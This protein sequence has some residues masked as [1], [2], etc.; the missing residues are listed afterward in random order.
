MY[1]I[2]VKVTYKESILDPQGQS[3]CNACHQLGFEGVR[4]VRVGK[5]FEVTL[6]VAASEVDET[7]R[8][9]CT[10]LLVNHTMETY[11]YEISEISE[12]LA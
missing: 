3:V 10:E 9:L 4:D 5:Y 12:V 7:V 1:L 6:D 11:T 8:A 2:K